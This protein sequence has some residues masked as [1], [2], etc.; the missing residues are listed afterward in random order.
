MTIF[1]FDIDGTV[2]PGDDGLDLPDVETALSAALQAFPDMLR[3]REPLSGQSR[4]QLRVRNATGPL[5][6]ITLD[7]LPGSCARDGA[8]DIDSTDVLDRAPP[9][10]PR[11]DL[12]A[13]T[14]LSPAESKARMT[15]D[16]ELIA[17]TAKR[18]GVDREA[19]AAALA[20]LKH[21]G[22]TMAQFSHPAFGGMAQW[23]KGGMSMIGDM[24]NHGLKATF[25]AVMSDLSA[26]LA[27]N[28]E[29]D[30]TRHDAAQQSDTGSTQARSDGDTHPAP[31]Q[32]S[33]PWPE[34]FG[35][36]GSSGGQNDM[37]Y[38]YFPE[39]CRLVI[40]QDG[41]RKIYDTGQ[42]RISGVSQQQAGERS[43]RFQSQ[44]GDVRLDEL[45]LAGE[46]DRH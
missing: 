26:A 34:E 38:A 28:P 7:L 23:S 21:G 16:D 13:T 45:S 32:T 14:S 25:D 19:V 24:F 4:F 41:T 11:T 3:D 30:D 44:Q 42:H 5:F 31:A 15:S 18:H 12:P 8:G 46:P 43:L 22:G 6:Q 36:P 37:R 40:D 2:D 35:T 1:F 10:Q 29:R 20:A 17:S 33:G 39:A 27:Q 9:P